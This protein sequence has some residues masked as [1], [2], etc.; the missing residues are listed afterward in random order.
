MSRDGLA[1][2]GAGPYDEAPLIG[3]DDYASA[4]LAS[5]HLLD[6]GHRQIA[7]LGAVPEGFSTRKTPRERLR[8]F[9][10]LMAARRAASAASSSSTMPSDS[11]RASWL[12]RIRSG[13]ER[14]I[15]GSITA[16]SL[17]AG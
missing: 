17:P 3:I 16:R 15:F 10:D 12:R 7:Y 4:T 9:R 13:S 11:P 2:D 5:E 6:L 14:K 8:G 1:V